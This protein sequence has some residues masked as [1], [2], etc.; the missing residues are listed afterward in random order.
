MKIMILYLMS[1]EADLYVVSGAR[2]V[3]RGTC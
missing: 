1:D 3:E 2:S